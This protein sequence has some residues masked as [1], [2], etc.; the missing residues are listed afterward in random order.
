MTSWHWLLP[1]LLLL[2]TGLA[3]LD[4]IDTH[5]PEDTP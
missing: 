5:N 2:V 4:S 3:C 1:V